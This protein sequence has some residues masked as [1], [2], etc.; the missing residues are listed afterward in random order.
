LAQKKLP[1]GAKYDLNTI[2]ALFCSVTT[3]RSTA[4]SR[5]DARALGLDLQAMVDVVRAT[6]SSHFYKSMP[7]HGNAAIFQDVYH[8]PFRQWTLYVKFTVD[9]GGQLLISLKEK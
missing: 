7:S 4:S 9:D 1:H 2:K 8:V 3:L 5:R 6:N